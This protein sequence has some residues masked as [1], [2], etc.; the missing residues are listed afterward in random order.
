MCEQ[1]QASQQAVHAEME[2]RQQTL[3]Q[4]RHADRLKTIGTLVSGM[5][6]ELGTPLN[7]VSGRAGLIASG[8]LSP[9]D[10]ADS[11]RII[12]EQVQR[13]TGIIRQLLDFTRRKT[14]KRLATDLRTLAHHTLDMLA[15]FVEQQHVVLTLKTEEAPVSVQVDAGQLQ[16]VLINLVTNAWQAMPQGGP[17]EVR[18]HRVRLIVGPFGSGMPQG[19]PVE[20]RIHRTEGARPPSGIEPPRG[21]CV[22][23]SVTDQGKGIAEA[24]L[25]HVFDPFFTTKGVGQGTGLGLSVAYG[26]VRDHGGWIE[27]TSQPG[28]GACFS[29]YLPMEDEP[30]PDAS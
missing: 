7:V 5:A 16:Q 13:M 18:I 11:A 10:V 19:G 14:P 17:V 30:C 25:P 20:V 8:R 1:L 22:C 21:S 24:D 3:E 29:V 23:V 6:H 4:L 9:A 12:K 28:A 27:V 15:P 26:I 2:A